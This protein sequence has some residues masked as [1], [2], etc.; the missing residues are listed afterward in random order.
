MPST[1]PGGKKDKLP[2]APLNRTYAATTVLHRITLTER[3]GNSLS[4]S[5]GRG[6]YSAPSM[7]LSRWLKDSQVKDPCLC[8]LW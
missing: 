7:A 8:P 1:P 6:T 2:V 3:C 4:S 5:L